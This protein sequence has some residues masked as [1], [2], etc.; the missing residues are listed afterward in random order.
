M[1]IEALTPLKI[2]RPAGDLL[3]TP[4][5]PVEFT[6]AEG[7]RLLE[8]AGGKVR[9]IKD[10]LRVGMIVEWESRLFYGLL[11]G[12]ILEVTANAVRVYHPLTEME[13]LIPRDWVKVID[14]DGTLRD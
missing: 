8:R 11:T 13:A 3:L 9:A 1:R 2:K 5:E 6:D 14:R 10:Q 7:R 12:V 4:G